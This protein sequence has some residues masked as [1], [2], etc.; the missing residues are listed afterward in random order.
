MTETCRST[1]CSKFNFSSWCRLFAVR[2]DSLAHTESNQ[3]SDYN[4]YCVRF[5]KSEK[6][7]SY[8][9]C[10][11]C[12]KYSRSMGSAYYL[13]CKGNPVSFF[14]DKTWSYACANNEKS[15]GT[16][17]KGMFAQGFAVLH[18]KDLPTWVNSI[19]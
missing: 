5:E 7:F 14:Q 4:S 6:L 18:A 10:S 11:F 1:F 12:Q 16:I 8:L 9:H 2:N 17:C 3:E 13:T 15:F 19:S